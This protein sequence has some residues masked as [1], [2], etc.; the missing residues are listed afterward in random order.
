MATDARNMTV[1]QLEVVELGTQSLPSTKLL[2][3]L[4]V[5]YCKLA[6]DGLARK[7]TSCLA[8]ALLLP[9]TLAPVSPHLFGV[10]IWRAR[11]RSRRS[12]VRLG[13]VA[14]YC[15]SNNIRL[16]QSLRFS[17]PCIKSNPRTAST[18]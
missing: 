12:V 14:A 17:I 18:S 16:L 1:K 10:Q 15:L 11:G 8:L 2:R 5:Q 6:F 4:K 13:Q 3:H 9:T 7:E